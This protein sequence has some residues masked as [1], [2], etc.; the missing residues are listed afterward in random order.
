MRKR[1]DGQM[2]GGFLKFFKGLDGRVKVA[3][4]GIGIQ[5]WGQ[6]LSMQYN[7]LYA[8]DLGA[9]AVALGLLNSIGA[10]VSSIVSVPLGLATEKYTVKR[11]M[12]LGLALTAISATIFILAGDWW[13]LIP[14]FIMGGRLIRIMPLTDIIF[15]TATKPEQRATIMSLSRV[16]WGMLDMFAPMMAA[17]IVASYGGINA[18]GIRPLYYIQLVLTI[19][20]LFF[21]AGKLQP[22]PVHND[23]KGGELGSKGMSFFREYRELFRGEKW[24]KRWIGLRIIQ[25]FGA[26]LAMPFVPLW[27][28]NVKGATPSILGMMGTASVV[29]S[30]ALQIPAGRLAD[31]VGRKKVFFLLRPI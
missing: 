10:A 17:L 21:I 23:R 4:A 28:V 12:L 9:D 18:Q 6:R 7:Q 27:M 29:M 25:Q 20:V 1:V 26:S 11:I 19:F 22:L 30:L 3:I 14:A 31:K 15:I 5:N 8:M 24:L 2:L 16:I 13:I